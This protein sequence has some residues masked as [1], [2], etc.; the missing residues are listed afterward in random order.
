MGENTSDTG[1]EQSTAKQFLEDFFTGFG[2]TTKDM[3]TDDAKLADL[4]D[5]FGYH[6][7]GLALEGA[8]P[9]FGDEIY[10]KL[11]IDRGTPGAPER[12]IIKTYGEIVEF[13]ECLQKKEEAKKAQE[14]QE[15]YQ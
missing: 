9:D 11:G 12:C 6:E 2:K 5:S 7:L 3:L 13:A 8:Y 14:T 10:D 4:L 1:T 15:K